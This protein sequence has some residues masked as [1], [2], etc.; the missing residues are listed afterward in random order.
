MLQVNF[1]H[2][3]EMEF[4]NQNNTRMAELQILFKQLV[5]TSSR[6]LVQTRKRIHCY[7]LQISIT[8]RKIMKSWRTITD[9]VTLSSLNQVAEQ[10]CSGDTVDLSSEWL[11]KRKWLKSPSWC[12]QTLKLAI[13]SDYNSYVHCATTPANERTLI[14]T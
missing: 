8:K 2:W 4:L 12:F 7:Q 11:Q 10:K 5:T 13:K 6:D 14:N 3:V 1:N 9:F